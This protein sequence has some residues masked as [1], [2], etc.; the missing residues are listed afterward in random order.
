[1]SQPQDSVAQEHSEKYNVGDQEAQQQLYQEDLS[2]PLHPIQPL[3]LPT[4]T[5]SSV[6][7]TRRDPRMAR[8]SSS[9]TVTH[10][11]AEKP[12]SNLTQPVPLP[13]IHPVDVG[14]KAQLPM[15]P[16]LPSSVAVI[17]SA[18]TRCC[19]QRYRY[20]YIYVYV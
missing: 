1:M 13:I 12:A 10:T 14:V 7:I 5:V 11:A 19:V 4:P 9:V 15:P 3:S 17:K 6:S 2:L 18:K 8:H 20:I 16:V